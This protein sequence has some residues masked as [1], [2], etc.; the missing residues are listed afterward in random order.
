MLKAFR[1]QRKLQLADY[2]EDMSISAQNRLSQIVIYLVVFN[3]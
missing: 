3:E 1:A 2:S